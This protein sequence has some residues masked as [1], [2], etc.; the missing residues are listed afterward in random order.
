MCPALQTEESAAL[1]NPSRGPVMAGNHAPRKK[2]PKA[3][4]DIR[5]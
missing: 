1:G 5:S 4:M 3:F 2:R